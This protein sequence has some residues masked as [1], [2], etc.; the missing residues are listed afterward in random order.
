MIADYFTKP[1]LGN[2][3]TVMRDILMGITPYPAK[4]RV[5]NKICTGTECK[6]V[7]PSTSDKGGR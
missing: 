1:L 7:K 4:E 2:L 5:G 6:D 3:F